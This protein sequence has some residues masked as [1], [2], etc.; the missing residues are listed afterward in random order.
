MAASGY[1]PPM[2]G[3]TPGHQRPSPFSHLLTGKQ[4]L[5]RVG[6]DK[7]YINKYLG[8]ATSGDY[9][10]LLAVSIEYVDVE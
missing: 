7:E 8:E 2:N 9:N 6:A 4:A 5:R 1:I 3:A 10:H